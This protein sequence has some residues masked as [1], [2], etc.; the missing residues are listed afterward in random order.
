MKINEAIQEYLTECEIRKYSPR[1]IRS[2]RVN[3][4]LFCRWCNEEKEIFEMDEIKI[5]TTRQFT[6]FMIQKGRKGTY[7]NGLLKS[8][9]S[10]LTYMWDEYE[11][12][13]N[14]KRGNFKWVKEE[15]P[16]IRAFK[17]SDVR[18][19]LNNCKG[20]GFLEIRDNCILTIFFES[21]IRCLELCSIQP[22]DVHE[23]Y[24]VIKGKNHKQRVVPVTAMM[25]K[26]M[27][28]YE[29]CKEN[30]FVFKPTENYYFLSFRGNMLTNSAVEHIF[31][32]RGE[33]IEDIRVSPH[34]ARHFFAQQQIKLGTDIYTISRLLGHENIG[35]TQIYLNSLRDD[36]VIKIAKQKSVLLNM[37]D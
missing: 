1:T 28:R 14:T 13:F 6:Q 10:F 36:E 16:V 25:R 12:G 30:Y 31:K 3:L 19:M 11:E 33:G 29:R 27:M 22:E 15:K 24:I 20:N 35:I 9:K 32:V 7:I 23:D 21:G 4:T 26:A 8:I 18:S 34:T 5:T 17:P 2:Y 37:E